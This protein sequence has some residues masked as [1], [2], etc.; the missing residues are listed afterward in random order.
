MKVVRILTL[1]ENKHILVD[2][3]STV[4]VKPKGLLGVRMVNDTD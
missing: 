3:S 2:K 4:R 1:L